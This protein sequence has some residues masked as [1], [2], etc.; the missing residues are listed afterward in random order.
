MTT[1]QTS[2][3]QIAGTLAAVSESRMEEDLVRVSDLGRELNFSEYRELFDDLL[4]FTSQLSSLAWEKLPARP[5]R[6]IL[7]NVNALA[8][9]VQEIKEFSSA[10]QG[11]SERDRYANQLQAALD[12]FKQIVVPYVGYLSWDSID[13]DGYQRSLNENIAEGRQTID[14]VAKEVQSDKVA[15]EEALSAIRAAAAEA[16]V[17]QE[18]ATFRDAAGRYAGLA[19]WWLVGAILGVAATI[20][21]AFGL[22]LLWDVSGQIS[23]AEV[24]QIVLAKAAALAVLSYA[25]INAVRLYRSNAHLA[26]VNRHREDALRTFQS[27]V[28]GTADDEVKDRILLAAANAAFGQTATGLIGDRGDGGNTVEVVEGLLGSNIRRP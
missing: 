24:L 7:D 21:A 12:A 23:D 1:E 13:L 17:S 5:Q 20:G 10:T 18:A 26:A 3:E 2:A 25:T 28:D 11:Q 14:R 19:Q 9:A 15:A 27:F 8:S 16:G 4:Q 22:V 6:D